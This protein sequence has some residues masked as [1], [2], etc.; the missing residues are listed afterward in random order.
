MSQREGK[1]VAFARGGK[2]PHRIEENRQETIDL[3]PSAAREE[4]DRPSG[5]VEP[6][7]AQGVRSVAGH[8]HAVEQW[9]PD[10]LDSGEARRIQRR[11]EGEHDR[12]TVHASGD[13]A[14]AAAAPRPDLRTDV[15][16][17]RH[18][19]PLGPPRQPEI[20]LR[21]VDQHAE[22]RRILSDTA[23]E[24]AV[25]AHEGAQTPCPLEQTDGCHLGRIGHGL[26]ARLA[27]PLAPDAEHLEVGE[28]RAQREEQIRSV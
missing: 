2:Q 6:V 26:H 19:C 28:L 3:A 1:L 18:A 14:H 23:G 20:E 24:F 25:C 17:H 27:Q 8:P 12:E 4:D 21:K 5:G 15:V 7:Q 10:E 13:L 9:M 16:Q 11:L 22:I